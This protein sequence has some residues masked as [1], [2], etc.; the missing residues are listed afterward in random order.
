M[1]KASY[2]QPKAGFTLGLHYVPL[3]KN[4]LHQC[5]QISLQSGFLFRAD[6]SKA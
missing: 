1:K 6:R 3:E 5:R 4:F 2:P